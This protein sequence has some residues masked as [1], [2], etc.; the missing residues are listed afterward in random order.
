MRH[1]K[2]LFLL[3]AGF[4]ILSARAEELPA[5]GL[6]LDLDAAKGL[7]M[8]DAMRVA[9]W[10]STV[11]G[12]RLEFVKRDEGRHAAGSGRPTLRENIAE[13]A[14]APAL[15]FLQQELVC[16][17]EDVFDKLVTGS[18]HTWAAVICVREQRKGL[19]DVNS[20]FGN[21]RNEQKFE[22]LWACFTDDNRPYYGVRNGLTF[23]RFDVNNPQLL[24]PAIKPGRFHLLVGRMQP[25]TGEVR[26]DFFVDDAKPVATTRVPVSIKANSSKL[27]VGQERDAIEHPGMESFDGEIARLLV[28]NRALDNDETARVLDQLR[29]RYGLKPR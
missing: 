7:E 5:N 21:L 29:Q 4:A 6:M 18:G 17:D 15:V 1:P 20:F 3:T 27:A 25:G 14:G 24:A 11:P 8:E 13:L 22:G 26:L 10:T 19:A 9:K 23:G 28:W 2:I 12:H 16:H